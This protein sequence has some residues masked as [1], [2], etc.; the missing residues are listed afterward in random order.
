M[1]TQ[2]KKATMNVVKSSDGSK[3]RGTKTVTITKPRFWV[4][5]V[6]IIGTAPLVQNKMSEAVIQELIERDTTVRLRGTRK[7]HQP[8]DLDNGTFAPGSEGLYFVSK[9]A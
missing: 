8:R 4:L 7:Y 6:E 3:I 1:T 5:D 2:R 9:N